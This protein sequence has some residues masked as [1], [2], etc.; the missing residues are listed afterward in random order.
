MQPLNIIRQFKQ[1]TILI[2]ILG[3]SEQLAQA[4]S[5]SLPKIDDIA[6]FFQGGELIAINNTRGEWRKDK[7]SNGD[8]QHLFG[9]GF[10]TIFE[11]RTIGKFD[12]ELSVGYDQLSLRGRYTDRYSL[13]GTIRNLPSISA[14]AQHENGLYLGI[15]T[16]LTTLSNVAA[17]ENGQ[18]VFTLSGDTFNLSFKG[19]IVTKY[20]P[21]IELAYHFRKFY[22]LGFG[23]GAPTDLPRTG[24]AS[25]FVLS[26][27]YQ[28]GLKAPPKSESDERIR[29]EA[30]QQPKRITAPEQQKTWPTRLVCANDAKN[31]WVVI[32]DR[33]DPAMCNGSNTLTPNVWVEASITDLEQEKYTGIIEICAN[34]KEPAGWKVVAERWSP[35]RCG[36][37]T[38]IENNI[39]QLKL[40]SD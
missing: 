33:W 26:I 5:L 8:T 29:A 24:D 17:Y 38:L 39:K 18:R 4:Q 6:F 9:W 2:L 12:L 40:K 20:G 11:M 34:S 31:G 28:F 22:G 15:G 37:P 14:Y 7:D 10:E 36:R 13:R 23:M 1:V 35:T 19:G 30:E 3:A 32:D 21:F 16:G 27:G 25:G